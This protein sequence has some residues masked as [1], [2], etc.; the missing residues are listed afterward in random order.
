MATITLNWPDLRNRMTVEMLQQAF[1][2]LERAAV[3]DGG[4]SWC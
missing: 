4:G 2:P 3:D 1:E